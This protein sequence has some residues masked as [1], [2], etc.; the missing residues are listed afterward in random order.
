MMENERLKNEVEQLKKK[1]NAVAGAS[2]SSSQG[3]QEEETKKNPEQESF[4]RHKLL[5]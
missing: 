2:S 3:T 4:N 1:L 5:N